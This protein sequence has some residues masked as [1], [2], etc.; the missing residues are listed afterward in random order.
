MKSRVPILLQRMAALRVAGAFWSRYA[1]RLAEAGVRQAHH[2]AAA[3]RARLRCFWDSTAG[4]ATN[5]IL[6]SCM[7]PIVCGVALFLYFYRLSVSPMDDTTAAVVAFRWP[8][9][10]LPLY[11]SLDEARGRRVAPNVSDDLG[12]RAGG[13][14]G[15]PKGS[16][17]SSD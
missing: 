4:V 8:T 2:W 1:L 9:S 14:S 3:A 5:L 11:R 13:I 6:I 12:R 15:R 16:V 17:Q 10:P 7:M